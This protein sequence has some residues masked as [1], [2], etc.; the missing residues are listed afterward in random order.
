M[1]QSWIRSED[2]T[3]AVTK[4]STLEMTTI[5]TVPNAIGVTA[6]KR[7]VRRLIMA[8]VPWAR[9]Q[10]NTTSRLLK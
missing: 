1:L 3:Q 10:H 5:K 6:F 4:A 9:H 7:I 2:P 8:S